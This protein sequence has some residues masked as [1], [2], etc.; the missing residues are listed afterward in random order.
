MLVSKHQSLMMKGIAIVFIVLSHIVSQYNNNNITLPMYFKYLDSLGVLGVAI[1]FF[2]SGYGLSVKNSHL[3]FFYTLK[4]ILFIWINVIIIRL[5]FEL[6]YQFTFDNKITLIKVLLYSLSYIE[7]Y[8]FICVISI[9]YMIFYFIS[10]LFR[11][12]NKMI[13]CITLCIFVFNYSL[14]YFNFPEEWYNV[15]FVFVV[16]IY[17]GLFSKQIKYFLDNNRLVSLFISSIGFVIGI[18]LSKYSLLISL[19]NKYIASI[20]FIVILIL[21][22]NSIQSK[23][24]LQFLNI[25]G[26]RSLLIY[27]IHIQILRFFRN[28]NY[29]GGFRLMLF[30]LI[31]YVSVFIFDYCSNK[32][33]NGFERRTGI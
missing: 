25:L 21:F 1:F 26:K 3:T 2:I 19:I 32:L 12:K 11:N 16:G 27:L 24:I 23:K 28:W 20:F 8:W 7:P 33:K 30:L 29:W 10:N 13:I 15:S 31:L 18:V 6:I 22:I 4:K 14:Y 9:F 17:F 5:V